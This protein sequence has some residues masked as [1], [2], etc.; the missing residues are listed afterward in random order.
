MNISLIA[1]VCSQEE[2]NEY[3]TDKIGLVCLQEEYNKYFTDKTGLVCSQ[4]EYNE[5]LNKQNWAGVF[6]RS[7]PGRSSSH[8]SMSTNQVPG[9][10]SIPR[11][12]TSSCRWNLLS[13]LPVWPTFQRP[14]CLFANK[15][16]INTLSLA[17]IPKT[18][19][20]VRRRSLLTLLVC[21]LGEGK[22][23]SATV[24]VEMVLQHQDRRKISTPCLL[25]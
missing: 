11:T 23:S 1:L 7:G 24:P 25:R 5:Y 2:C 22:A 3:F 10:A 9:P 17:N 12:T 14:H 4:E 13:T 19:S 21:E 20:S 18:T 15:S 6:Q 16:F 8:C